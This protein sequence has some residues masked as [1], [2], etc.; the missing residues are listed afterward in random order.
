MPEPSLDV[1][2][3]AVRGSSQDG[4]SDPDVVVLVVGSLVV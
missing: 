4:R 3:E 1:L 2:E